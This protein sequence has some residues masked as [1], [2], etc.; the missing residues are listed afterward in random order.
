MAGPAPDLSA[1]LDELG[2]TY[3]QALACGLV[4]GEVGADE[5]E[6]GVALESHWH[7]I[8]VCREPDRSAA[9]SLALDPPTVVVDPVADSLD[10]EAVTGADGGVEPILAR[11]AELEL[12]QRGAVEHVEPHDPPG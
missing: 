10:A 7:P 1:G 6:L 12:D 8:L 5:A 4:A 3:Y 9:S 11:E 2:Q